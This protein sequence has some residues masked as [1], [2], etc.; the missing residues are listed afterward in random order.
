MEIYA[1]YN[2]RQATFNAELNKQRPEGT[3]SIDFIT[4]QVIFDRGLTHFKSDNYTEFVLFNVNS[5]DI[6]AMFPYKIF[7][8]N[9]TF[10]GGDIK[11]TMFKIV[12]NDIASGYFVRTEQQDGA[13]A[14]VESKSMNVTVLN[15]TNFNT[16][17]TKG[18]YTNQT[19]ACSVSKTGGPCNNKA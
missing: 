3:D 2:G 13:T 9:D 1:L 16:F 18:G 7:T 4:L 5:A 8:V 10:E 15:R 14:F 6:Q 11:C 19:F 12:L 17:I